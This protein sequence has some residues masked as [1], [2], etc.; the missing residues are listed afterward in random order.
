M[1]IWED[2]FEPDITPD[3]LKLNFDTFVNHVVDK[4]IKD[5][6]KKKRKKTFMIVLNLTGMSCRLMKNPMMMVK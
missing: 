3:Y 6:D 4:H 2:V 5:Q 1:L